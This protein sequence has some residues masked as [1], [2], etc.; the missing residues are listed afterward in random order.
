M[1]AVYCKAKVKEASSCINSKSDVGLS[2]YN[3]IIFFAVLYCN[4]YVLIINYN[5]I[6]LGMDADIIKIIQAVAETVLQPLFGN[7][8]L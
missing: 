8:G 5:I 1:C 6:V 4:R 2:N 7:H 3:Y